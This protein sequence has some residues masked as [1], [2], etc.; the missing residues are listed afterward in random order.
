MKYE[1]NIASRWGQLTAE[2][3][4]FRFW[5]ATVA[6]TS[7]GHG[8]TYRSD[9]QILWWSKGGVL[10]G[11]SPACLAF[12]KQ[13]LDDAPAEGIEPIEKWSSA[14]CGGRVPDYYLVYLGKQTPTRWEF[15]L[16]KSPQGRRRAAEGMKF[17]AEVLKTW[18]ISVTAVPG[19]FTL[20]GRTTISSGIKT[21]AASSCPG[22]PTWRFGSKG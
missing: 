14:E 4:V 19:T 15:K 8:E 22:S 16:P 13:V 18:N 2:E 11:Q 10:K 9:D 17:T 12:L 21:G 3:M 20:A 5:N 1:G 7:C 6:G